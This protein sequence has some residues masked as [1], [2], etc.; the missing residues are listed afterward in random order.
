MKKMLLMLASLVLLS[1]IPA[2]GQGWVVWRANGTSVEQDAFYYSDPPFIKWHSLSIGYDIVDPPTGLSYLI[3][4]S[5]DTWEGSGYLSFYSGSD[6]AIRQETTSMN[7][8]GHTDIT[9]DVETGKMK[10]AD[11]YI[12]TGPIEIGGGGGGSSFYGIEWTDGYENSRDYGNPVWYVDIQNLV[13]HEIGHAL[14][15]EHHSTGTGEETMATREDVPDFNTTLKRRT[16]EAEDWEALDFLYENLH[17]ELE[18]PTMNSAL[19]AL[20]S[21]G[22]IYVDGG[23]APNNMTISKDVTIDGTWTGKAITVNSGKTLT[24]ESGSAVTFQNSTS[25]EVSGTLNATG[26]TFDFGSPGSSNG[27]RFNSGSSG[28]LDGVTITN[29][30][31]GIYTTGVLPSIENSTI[32]DSGTGIYLNNV[33]TTSTRIYDSAIHSN[34][35]NGITA[36]YSSFR[37]EDNY[38]AGNGGAGIFALGSAPYISGNYINISSSGSGISLINNSPAKLYPYGGGGG[39]NFIAATPNGMYAEHQSNAQGS[40]NDILPSSSSGHYA[41]RA[42]GTV[43]VQVQYNYWGQSPADPGD[44]HATNG[45]LILYGSASSS[46]Y[47]QWWPTAP[48]AKAADLPSEDAFDGGRV[49]LDEPLLH[50]SQLVMEGDYATAIGLYKHALEADA[51]LET[52]QYILYQLADAYRLAERKDFVGFLNRAV[53]RGLSESDPLYATTLE[54]EHFEW[55]RQNRYAEAIDRLQTLRAGFASDTRIDKHALFSLGYIHQELLDDVATGHAYFAEF[56]ARYPNDVLASDAARFLEAAGASSKA[57]A[58]TESAYKADPAQTVARMGNY[59]NPFN[60]QTTIRFTLPKATN[61]RLVVYDVLG[62]EVAT[63]V[64]AWQVAGSHEARFDASQ[65]PSGTY[66]YQLQTDTNHIVKQ[67]LLVR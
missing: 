63:L 57:L 6:I 15:L 30:T 2:F 7:R 23:S 46:P 29:A 67:M 36:Y 3:D 21:G 9:F 10:C 48:Y 64:N 8:F 28:S 62:R 19:N 32:K 35:S 45:A 5:F 60:P 33:N 31:Y 58:V 50:A 14:G 42:N 24:L 38:I 51:T 25:L 66:F 17:V 20:P 11:I 44:F 43:V 37:I 4:D 18:H 52:K 55:V 59:P 49:I 12:N 1:V 26:T 65:L 41:V 56:Q 34:S 53:R 47:T 16:P 39:Y 22:T 13:T 27:I 61:V 54:L 40:G